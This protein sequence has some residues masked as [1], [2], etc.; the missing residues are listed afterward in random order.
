MPEIPTIGWIRGEKLTTEHLTQAREMLERAFGDG[1]AHRLLAALGVR[2]V[3]GDW[4]SP[5]PNLTEDGQDLATGSVLIN[6]REWP[7][8]V[9]PSLLPAVILHG[10][11]HLYQQKHPWGGWGLEV[12]AYTGDL[13]FHMLNGEN[14]PVFDG[15][16]Y[17]GAKKALEGAYGVT[18]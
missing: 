14:I 15:L 16:V 17:G 2:Y 10:A 4:K 12:M 1:G 6:D 8:V 5:Y 11:I 9:F 18:S 3:R 7:M 13:L